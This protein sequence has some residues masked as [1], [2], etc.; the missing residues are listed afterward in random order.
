MVTAA[1]PSA[2]SAFAWQPPSHQLTAGAASLIA[3]PMTVRQAA[4]PV[5][6]QMTV[7]PA[8]LAE[9]LQSNQQQTVQ[10]APYQQQVCAQTVQPEMPNQQ[11]RRSW[12]DPNAAVFDPLWNA[13]VANF[14]QQRI[15]LLQTRNFHHQFK[16]HHTSR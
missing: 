6:T 1:A 4:E 13:A 10:L 15:F 16:L 12:L 14:P 7:I 2:S 3:D 8:N 11:S 5:G 9:M